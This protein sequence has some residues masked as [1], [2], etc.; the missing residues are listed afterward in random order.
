MAQHDYSIANQSGSAFRTDLNN[1]LSAIVSQNSGSTA[2]SP[3]YAY[4]TWADTTT[5]TLKRRNSAN[6]AWLTVGDLTGLILSID[7]GGQVGIGTTT[8][9]NYSANYDDLVVYNASS[10]GGIT[11]ATGSSAT[12]GLAFADGT[13]GG[14][15]EY[16]GFVQY[17]HTTDEIQIGT[18]GIIRQWLGQN[19]TLIV[20]A[21]TNPVIASSQTSAGT[22][23]SFFS[24]KHTATA[25]ARDTGTEAFKV[26]TNG[27]VQNTN[28]SYGSL[29][30]IK[31]KQNIVDANSQWN[32]IK[33]IRVRNYN[34]KQGQTHTQIGA[35]AQEVEL[36]SPGLVYES[37]D[38]DAAGN[39]LGTVTKSINYSVL[40]MKSVKALQEAM[41]RIEQ[42]EIKVDA[43]LAPAPVLD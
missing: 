19:G 36:I 38:C 2:P 39:D 17:S 34:L 42:L 29:S 20:S 23:S 16:R 15:D 26:F 24:G 27:N 11:I 35:I 22:D 3:T 18:S 33:A 4:M 30:D 43:L 6:N 7:T 8:P 37:A 32:D 5:N 41:E 1:A 14:T 10:N 31:L 28:N 12:G 40:Y 21:L 13:S 9:S 25:G